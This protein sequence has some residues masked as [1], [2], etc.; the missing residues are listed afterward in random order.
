MK[1]SKKSKPRRPL[2]NKKEIQKRNKKSP[3]TK[4]ESEENLIGLLKEYEDKLV[5]YRFRTTRLTDLLSRR[6]AVKLAEDKKFKMSKQLEEA[7]SE[8]AFAQLAIDQIR[9]RI[10]QLPEK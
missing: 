5:F 8:Y 9:F 4:V 2:Q 6:S 7:S 10:S 3:K 1:K